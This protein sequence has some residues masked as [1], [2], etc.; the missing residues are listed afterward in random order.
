MKIKT[1]LNTGERTYEYACINFSAEPK[2]D[3]RV[4]RLEQYLQ[5][6][7]FILDGEPVVLV[8]RKYDLNE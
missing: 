6:N 8:N 1:E 2:A 3:K 7:R 5:A 4:I